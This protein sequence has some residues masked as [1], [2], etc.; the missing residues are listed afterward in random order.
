MVTTLGSLT[1]LSSTPFVSVLPGPT[2]SVGLP[3]VHLSDVLC[4]FGDLLVVLACV[5]LAF[6]VVICGLELVPNAPA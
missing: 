5:L 3:V 6:E 2:E 1:R 4:T